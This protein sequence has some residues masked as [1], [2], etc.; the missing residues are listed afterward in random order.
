ME[1]MEDDLIDGLWEC[2]TTYTDPLTPH[3][4]LISDPLTPIA[5]HVG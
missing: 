1:I 2:W 3:L 4:P 5:T